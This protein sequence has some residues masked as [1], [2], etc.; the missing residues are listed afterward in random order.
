MVSFDRKVNI[1]RYAPKIS[2]QRREGAKKYRNENKLDNYPAWLFLCGFA[3]LRPDVA[4][5]V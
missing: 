4:L 3:P 5:C 2:T 1:K